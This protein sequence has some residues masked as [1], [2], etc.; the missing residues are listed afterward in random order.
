MGKLLVVAT[1][2]GN[3]ED[4]TIRALKVLKEVDLI[5]CEDTRR[6]GLLLNNYQI[7]KPLTSFHQHSKIQRV[8]EIISKLKAGQNVALVTDAGMPAIADPGGVLIAEALRHNIEIDSIPGP[9]AVSTIL[10]VSGF[11]VD[12]YIFLGF[13]PKKKGRETAL[14][15]IAEIK[16]PVVLFESPHRIIRTLE[17]IHSKVGNRE[18]VVGRELTKMFQEVVRGNISDILTKIKPKGEFV[19]VVKNE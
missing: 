7:R 10:S 8:D 12:K 3:L 2:I 16:V 15:L 11:P 17:D 18:V 1:P 5:A 4:I 13:L 14:K 19:M 6:T 9:D